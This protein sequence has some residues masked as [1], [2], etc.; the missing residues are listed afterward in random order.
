[1][2][3]VLIYDVSKWERARTEN[4]KNLKLII[5]E[6]RVF[7]PIGCIDDDVAIDISLARDSMTNADAIALSEL[8]LASGLHREILGPF[9]NAYRAL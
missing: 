1:M 4:F 8:D 9:D 6:S 5:S 7:S 3:F 2:C